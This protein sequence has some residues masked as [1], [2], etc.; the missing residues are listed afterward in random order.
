[1]WEKY[2]YCVIWFYLPFKS[3]KNHTHGWDSLRTLTVLAAFL[4]PVKLL[5][6]HFSLFPFLCI[7]C[8]PIST[9]YLGSYWPH[10][11]G[12]TSVSHV[13]NIRE[14]FQVWEIRSSKGRYATVQST[15]YQRYGTLHR[16]NWYQEQLVINRMHSSNPFLQGSG[17]PRSCL[18]VSAIDKGQVNF[19]QRRN[20]HW[21]YKPCLCLRLGAYQQC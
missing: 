7:S 20:I 16:Y 13:A 1:M 10:Q 5:R 19:H 6:P 15:K 3:G 9:L 4:T 11:M 18:Q 14:E 8:L 2:K 21:V 12:I 17:D